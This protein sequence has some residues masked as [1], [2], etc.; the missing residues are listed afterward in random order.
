[1]AEK[2]ARALH[3]VPGVGSAAGTPGLDQAIAA[4]HLTRATTLAD[5]EKEYAGRLTNAESVLQQAKADAKVAAISAWNDAANT[6]WTAYQLALARAEDTYVASSNYDSLQ[7]AGHMADA[8]HEETVN[9]ATDAA[10]QADSQGYAQYNRQQSQAAALRDETTGAATAS[11]TRTTN[12]AAL[13]LTEQKSLD[14]ADHDYI[15]TKADAADANGFYTGLPDD[16]G[17]KASSRGNSL[18]QMSQEINETTDNVSFVLGVLAQYLGTNGTIYANASANPDV[19]K[20]RFLYAGQRFRPSPRT[21][22]RTPSTTRMQLGPR[23]T[24]PS[25]ILTKAITMPPKSNTTMRS[26]A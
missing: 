23:R 17:G 12:E 18:I 20:D 25:F 3:G 1:M 16:P 15:T 13:V 8:A 4:A 19:A 5:A 7:Y 24:T 21:T 22:T 11:Y 2:I 6:P 14:H 9:L 10:T 26:P